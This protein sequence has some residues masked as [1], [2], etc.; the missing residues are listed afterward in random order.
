MA[1]G[2]KLDRPLMS[3][4]RWLS[5]AYECLL[6]FEEGASDQAW[7]DWLVR[8]TRRLDKRRIERWLCNETIRQG[9]YVAGLELAEHC[10]MT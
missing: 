2:I 8:E 7:P 1:R 9:D 6:W 3:E 5:A 4:D 10:G